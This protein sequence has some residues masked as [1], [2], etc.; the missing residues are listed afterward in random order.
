[1]N[2]QGEL[3][4]IE[5][6][7]EVIIGSY[8]LET[9]EILGSILSDIARFGERA[10][11]HDDITLIIIKATGKR[12][13][14]CRTEMVSRRENIPKIAGYIKKK[15]SERGFDEVQISEMQ[16]AVEEAY[17][18]IINHGYKKEEGPIWI[19]FDISD[20]LFRVTLEDEAPRFDPTMFA[21][22]DLDGDA[23]DHPV[24][25]WGINLMRTLSDEMRYDYKNN[26]NRL[27][28]IKIK[29]AEKGR[30]NEKMIE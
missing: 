20:R 27:I 9:E 4:G 22:R 29:K 7:K 10:E 18:N 12:K 5:R 6:L 26:K 24:G 25:G 1:M 2:K 3:Y 30:L 19:A 21:K 16:V 8:L 15:M 23:L 11:Q 14:H 13:D 28:L 17:V